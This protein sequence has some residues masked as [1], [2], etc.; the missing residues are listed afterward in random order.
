MEELELI[1]IGLAKDGLSV[2]G[3]DLLRAL[4][5]FLTSGNL[6]HDIKIISGV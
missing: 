5:I 1:L 4:Y 3:I 6:A 2:E